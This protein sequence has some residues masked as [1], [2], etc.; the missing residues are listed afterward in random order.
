MMRNSL[1]SQE[2]LKQLISFDTTSCYSNLNLIQRI[3]DELQND[4]INIRLTYNNAGDK[5]NLFATFSP[6]DHSQHRGLVLSGHTDVVPVTGQE[7]NTDPFTA[8]TI[9]DRIY[10]RG[11]CDMKGFI[12]VVLALIP[13]FKE[14]KLIKPL[15]LAFTYDEE[16]G[17][18]GA[19]VLIKDFQQ[20]GIQPDACIVGEPTEMRP[21]IAHKGINAL[22]CKVKGNAMHSSLTAEGCNAIDYASELIGW[23]R[24]LAKEFRE[25][26]PY[27]TF[28]DVPYSSLSTNIIQGGNAI[29]TVPGYCEFFFDFRNLPEAKP[30]NFLKEI[31]TYVQKELLPKMR[32]E[33]SDASIEI[34]TIASAPAFEISEEEA[35]TRLTRKLTNDTSTRKVSY[36]TEAGL[37]QNAN[38]QTIL[39]GPGSIEQAHRPNEFV[40]I[41]QLQ[42]CEAFLLNLVNDFLT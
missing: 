19:R 31:K 2:W 10:G 33:Y 15:H 9:K 30:E 7:W 18:D 27:D 3:H 1:T 38:I 39:C 14:L 21:V 34:D 25:K 23:I 20:L 22:R 35:I 41:P 8:T 42:K 16:V 24:H 29:N 11:A 13:K 36:G 6:D 26:G 40:T 12:A 5:A 4:N 28:F 17:C 32:R 37:F